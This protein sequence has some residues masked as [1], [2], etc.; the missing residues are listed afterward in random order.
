MVD[1][2]CAKHFEIKQ[3]SRKGGSDSE[4]SRGRL[5]LKQANRACL[6]GMKGAAALL[7]NEVAFTRPHVNYACCDD[8]LLCLRKAPS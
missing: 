1:F 5:Q 3:G 8:R 7:D 4:P 2:L 6:F